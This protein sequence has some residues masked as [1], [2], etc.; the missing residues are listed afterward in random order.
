MADTGTWCSGF[1]CS[2]PDVREYF[3]E[4]VRHHPAPLLGN[5]QVS[6]SQS[7]PDSVE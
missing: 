7:N 4:C 1:L 3:R 6:A 2:S 5:C